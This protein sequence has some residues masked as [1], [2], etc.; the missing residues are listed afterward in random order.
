M[1]HEGGW[2]FISH[3]HQDIAI[4]RRIRN[5]L[6][7]LGFEPLLFFLKSLNDDDEI[8]GLIE[9]EIGAREWFIYVDSASA[10]D[11]R[12]VRSERSYVSNL[13]DKK[14]FTISIDG[15]IDEQVSAIARQLQ[16]FISYAQQDEP[17][18]HKIRAKLLG[19][20]LLVLDEAGPSPELPHADLIAERIG[21]SSRDGFV[22]VIISDHSA[23]SAS[24]LHEVNYALE[25][26]GKVIPVYV[27]GARAQGELGLRVGELQGVG[28]S[29]DPSEEELERL[30]QMIE[31]R[32]EYYR[33]DFRD[34][35][36]YRSA[37]S[38]VLPPI[39]IIDN[40]TFWDC[41]NLEEVTIPR[42]VGFITDDA[43]EDH[44]DIL[45]RCE[46]DSF[47]A[48]WCREHGMRWEAC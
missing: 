37:R 45:V 39:G 31:R 26:H 7:S 21:R 44:P 6:E 12:W 2:V 9:R 8:E 27:D 14:I 46:P 43:F 48:T 28:I 19:H 42:T 25:Q 23:R 36:G 34:G 41:P 38:I 17:L 30:Y 16:V 11:S 40:M 47:A 22:L 29:S 35:S 3:S 18:V 20:D 33:S 32:V 10:R 4:V 13:A 1:A 15:N 5:R 24:L